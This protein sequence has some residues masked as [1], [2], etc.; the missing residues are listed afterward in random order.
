MP[1]PGL[2]ARPC[3][4]PPRPQGCAGRRETS[5]AGHLPCGGRDPGSKPPT[6]HKSI[7]KLIPHFPDMPQFQKGLQ[8][9]H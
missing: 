8:R 5:T 7:I 4:Q 2:P 6:P 1:S 3:E 9:H